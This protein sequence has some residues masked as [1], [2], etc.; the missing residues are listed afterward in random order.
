MLRLVLLVGF[1]FASTACVTVAP[2]SQPKAEVVPTPDI[3]AAVQATMGVQATIQAAVEATAR[4]MVRPTETV[5][6]PRPAEASATSRPADPTAPPPVVVVVPGP[7]T[8]PPPPAGAPAGLWIAC[9]WCDHGDRDPRTEAERVAGLLR[10]AGI[11]AAVLWS[12]DYPSLNPGYWVTYSGVFESEQSATSHL[13]SLTQ[14]GFN[15]RVRYVGGLQ[16]TG[17][18]CRPDTRVAFT[19]EWAATLGCYCRI[20]RRAV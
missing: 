18:L 3:S 6:T 12:S 20:F 11:P 2:P 7:G 5:A 10:T 16:W 4:T 9:V 19:F 17:A 1:V 8:Q 15:G 14:A 13:T